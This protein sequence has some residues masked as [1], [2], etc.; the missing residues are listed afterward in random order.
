MWNPVLRQG[1]AIMFRLQ[2]MLKTSKPIIERSAKRNIKL[3]PFLN[4]SVLLVARVCS[5]V[6][7]FLPLVKGF[8]IS[9]VAFFLAALSSRV[10]LIFSV[11]S[12]LSWSFCLFFLFIY[13]LNLFLLYYI[14]ILHI[15]KV[16][17][18]SLSPF[19]FNFYLSNYIWISLSDW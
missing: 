9:A 11:L 17:V 2:K 5:L 10:W 6:L 16:I 4:A 3:K 18:W 13:L 1:L 12:F 14:L 7:G 19:Y 8:W 15:R